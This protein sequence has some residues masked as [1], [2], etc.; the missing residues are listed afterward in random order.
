M[1]KLTPSKS[2]LRRRPGWT[3]GTVNRHGLRFLVCRGNSKG[4][5]P[6]QA[7]LVHQS[8]ISVAR[9]L[10]LVI[11]NLLPAGGGQSVTRC[12]VRFQPL[13]TLTSD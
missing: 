5:N 6:G 11:V 10:E 3:P 8:L 7:A 4:G 12:S 2:A 1:L 9:D 13:A